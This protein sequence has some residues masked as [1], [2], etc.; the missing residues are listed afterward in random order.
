MNACP[1][2]AKY[3]VSDRGSIRDLEIFP[4]LKVSLAQDMILSCVTRKGWEA[5]KVKKGIFFERNEMMQIS[6]FAIFE[7][8]LN[9]WLHDGLTPA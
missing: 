1:M 7:G 2:D 5:G 3:F 8:R 4:I 9:S 6:S